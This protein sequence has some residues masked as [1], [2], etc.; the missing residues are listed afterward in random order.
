[1]ELLTETIPN[2]EIK[3]LVI[4]THNTDILQKYIE[5]LMTANKILIQEVS[6]LKIRTS[7]VEEEQKKLPDICFRLNVNE[8]KITDIYESINH[9]KLK[10]IEVDRKNAKFEEVMI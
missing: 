8:R 2:F 6:D 3:D 4:F 10:F 9:F 7:R 1:M 5:Y